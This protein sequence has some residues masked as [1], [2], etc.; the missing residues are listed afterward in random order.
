[1]TSTVATLTIGGYITSGLVAYWRLNDGT[2]TNA[3]DS[4]GNGVTMPLYGNPTWGSNYI[5]FS[6][7]TNQYGDAG[8]SQLTSLDTNDFTICAWIN[9][10]GTNTAGSS[11]QKI[12]DKSYYTNSGNYGGWQFYELNDQL[13]L[14]IMYLES[15]RRQHRDHGF[16]PM[17][18]RGDCLALFFK[19]G[20]LL[21]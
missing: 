1:M 17:D 18:V 6:G 15:G 14:T 13:N 5:I 12:L 16:R 7:A 9:Q 20:G 10:M 3:M 2:G 4:S 11:Y 8:P 21:C 19:H